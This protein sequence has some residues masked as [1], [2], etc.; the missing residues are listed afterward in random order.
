MNINIYIYDNFMNINMGRSHGSGVRLV[1]L[2]IMNNTDFILCAAVI[3]EGLPLLFCVC[4][5]CF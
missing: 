2:T 1:E 4:L 3:R 5:F